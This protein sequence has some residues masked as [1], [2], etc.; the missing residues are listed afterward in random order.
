MRLK[1]TFV[2]LA[3]ALLA[4]SAALADGYTGNL[5]VGIF[6]RQGVY[7]GE[8]VQTN[9]LPYVYGEW[10]DFFGRVDT[11]GYRIMPMGH[12][13]L[14]VSTRIVQDEMNSDRLKRTGVRARDNSRMLGVSTFQFTPIGAVSMSL[15]QDFGDSTGQLLDMS[16]IGAF[17]PTAWLSIYPELGLEVMS[18]RYTRYYYGVKAGEGGYE[19]HTPSMAVNPYFAIHAGMPLSADWN[20]AVTIRNKALSEEISDSPIV[21]HTGR[22][23]A[24]VAASYKFK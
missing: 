24:Y 10:G 19:D 1:L 3:A 11:F 6:S 22:W 12:G 8:S 18:G 17:K 5:G 7:K 20:L 14:E 21:A 16:W 23:N 2:P 13:F 9:V 15:M 4:S